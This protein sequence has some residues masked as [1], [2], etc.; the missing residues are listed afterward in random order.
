MRH[1]GEMRDHPVD[2]YR[3]AHVMV[4]RPACPR[5]RGSD[6]KRLLILIAGVAVVVAGLAGFMGPSESAAAG[7][8]CTVTGAGLDAEETQFLGLLQQWRSSNLGNPAPLETSGALNSAAA[9]FAQW[10]VE[11]SGSG[12]HS[13]S[14]G[15]NWAQR[16]V[17]CGYDPFFSNGSGEGVYAVASSGALS[18][19]PSQAITGIS[20]QGSGVRIVSS[21][22]S[23]PAKCVGVAVKRNTAGTIVAWVVVIAQYPAGSACPAGSGSTE[24]PASSATAISSAT[25]T[26]TPTSTPTKTPTPTP[27][28][29]GATINLT[30]GWNLVVIPPGDLDDVLYRAK[31]CFRSV[32]QQQGEHWVRYSPEVPAYARNLQ[33]SNG[34]V[35]WVE[36]TAEGCGRIPL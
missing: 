11:N 3:I 8:P 22:P 14:F 29:D 20:Y 5:Q 33:T 18:I 17:D 2:V 19:G 27:R 6:L 21:S 25:K 4:V 26:A 36:G 28:T 32:Y 1:G 30:S 16:A 31:G 15:R 34:G 13:D 35:F 9:W 24:P 23:W 10:Q 12:G 7:G